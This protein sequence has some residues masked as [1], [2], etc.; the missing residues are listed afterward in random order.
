MTPSLTLS[1]PEADIAL[2]TFDLSGK[3]ANILSLSVLGELAALLDQLQSRSVLA[4]LV[5]KS[6][7]PGTFIAGADI[8][9]FLA[10]LGAP[11]SEVVAMCRRGQSLFARLSQMPFVSVAA[12]DGIC[13]GGGAELAI[14]CDR[15]VMADSPKTEYGFPEVKLGLY[16]GWGG[17]VR[18]PRIVG[19]ANALEMITT[20][21]NI[22]PRTALV[23]GLA[24]DVVP[25]E[26]L[27]AAAIGVVRA[28]KQSG[29][30]L[31]DRQRW[32][33][34]IAVE[35]TELGFLGA[36]ASAMIQQETKGQYP[37]PMAALELMLETC[38][39]P[40]AEA[41]EREA[42][43]MASLF[44]SPVNAALIN[45]FFL[46][47]RNKRDTGLDRAGVTAANV[48]SVGV[49]GSGIMG[50]GIAGATLKN[51]IPIA[52]TDANADALARGA[53]QL[54]EEAAYNK[55]LKGP[56]LAK[57]L[58]LAPLLAVT[59]RL[60]EIATAD[61]V[62]E[63]IVEKE[64]VKKQLYAKLEP[65][66]A[67]AAILASNTS[68]IPITRLAEGLARPER[69]CGIHFFNPVRRMKLVEV[70]RGAKTSDETVAT[71]V[72][73]AKRIG[74]SP[75]VVGDGPGFLVNRLL[76]PYMNEA[77]ELLCDGASIKEIDRAA[78]A[79]GMP[80]GPLTLY[81]LVGLDT[82]VYAGMVMYQAFP[83]R[84]VAA[85]LVPAMVKL[86]R[87]GQK[88]GKGF[89]SYQN[90]KGR[91][92]EDPEVEKIIATYR[93]GTRKFSRDELTNRLFLPM[94][95]EATRMLDEKIVRDVR[96]V[97]LG[98]IFGLGFPPFQGGL[99]FWA[100]RVGAKKL[101]E[102][103]KPLAPLG[104]RFEPTPLLLD[105][106]AT[107]RKFYAT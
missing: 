70:I 13:V 55:K 88:S 23:M 51:E 6:G 43:G 48:K 60:E 17:T 89:F 15:R 65:M 3:G 34:P 10:S 105:M 50:G 74:K 57:T 29:Q 27:L 16:P 1:F 5:I 92:E 56:D 44:G 28:E 71:A 2:I 94:L 72:A 59:H 98:L 20:G 42:E 58:K 30:Y 93:R 78:T 79:F 21:E 31:T 45:V 26:K 49:L 19:L 80:M 9:E 35:P 36:T 95:L 86:G 66:L 69:F 85:P 76:F 18:A 100:D 67:P 46:T 99:L 25:A 61:L 24:S 104:K 84:V 41:Y 53:K 91:A 12:I 32:A 75:I 22:D 87:L 37:A 107:G 81:D 14:G 77:I 96:D 4:G 101:V 40:A 97:D 73:F 68:T 52:L 106:A 63:A 39:M 11:K 7:K 47:D 8:R 102:M 103:A 33:Q 62:I 38:Q 64:D 54:L 83:E 82:A 90:K